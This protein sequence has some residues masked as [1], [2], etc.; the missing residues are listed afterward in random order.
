MMKNREIAEVS[1]EL[2]TIEEELEEKG[3]KLKK[4][5]DKLRYM[6]GKVRNTTF[7]ISCSLPDQQIKSSNSAEW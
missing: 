4:K 6:E 3:T 2:E 1:S 7:Y 5:S